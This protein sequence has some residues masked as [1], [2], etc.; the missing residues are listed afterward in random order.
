MGKATDPVLLNDWHVLAK[1]DD[2][3]RGTVLHQRLLDQEIVLWRGEDGGL[4]A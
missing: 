3:P 2:L 4:Q 1:V